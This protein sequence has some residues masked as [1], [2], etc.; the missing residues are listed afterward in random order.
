MPQMALEIRAALNQSLHAEL[1]ALRGFISNSLETHTERLHGDLAALQPAPRVPEAG[2]PPMLPERR[3]WAAI[4]GW[5]SCV[6]AL[7]GA[8]LAGWLW[9]QQG[10]EVAALRTDLA[11]AYAEV[12][13]LRARPVVVSPSPV[14]AG[15]AVDPNAVTPAGDAPDAAAATSS[16]VVL[17]PAGTSLDSALQAASA[18]P[19]AMPEAATPATPP[20][21]APAA[22]AAPPVIATQPGAAPAQ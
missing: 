9:W 12:E 18:A 14:A 4:L 20:A 17:V 8:G 22:A 10:A 15:P 1:G 7:A 11:A 13:T 16:D 2:L 5:S 21:S 19:A 3:N 6:L